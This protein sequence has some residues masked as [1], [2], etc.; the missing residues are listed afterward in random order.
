MS[1][2]NGFSVGVPKIQANLCQ[3]LL[4]SVFHTLVGNDCVILFLSFLACRFENENC[5]FSSIAGRSLSIQN[6][7]VIIIF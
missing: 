7:N 2:D 4:I 1:K 3:H 5:W 6:K